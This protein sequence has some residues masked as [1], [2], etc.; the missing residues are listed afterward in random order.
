MALD[1]FIVMENPGNRQGDPRSDAD[2]T[3]DEKQ[4]K[5]GKIPKEVNTTSHAK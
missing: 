3:H 2:Q 1:V 5:N 4:H